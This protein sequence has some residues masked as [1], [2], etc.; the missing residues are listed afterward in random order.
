MRLL[1]DQ[2][3][4]PRLAALLADLYAGSVHVRERGLQSADDEVV[5]ALARSDGFMI[6]SKDEDFH[7]RSLV[8]GHPPKVIWIRLGNCSTDEIADL[9]RRRFEEIQAFE[10]DGLASFLALG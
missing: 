4:S 1:F 8:I 10:D 3:L 9:L 2:N 5:W 7:Q 6:V